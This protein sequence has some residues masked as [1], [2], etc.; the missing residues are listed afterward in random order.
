VAAYIYFFDSSIQVLIFLTLG[1]MKQ[2]NTHTVYF[3]S[4]LPQPRV[5]TTKQN[6]PNW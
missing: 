5:N 4:N 1:S 3:V 2:S 6:S